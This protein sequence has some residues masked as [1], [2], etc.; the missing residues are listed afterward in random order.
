MY[1]D[2]YYDNE[3]GYIKNCNIVNI[4]EISNNVKYITI[5][6]LKAM[7][8]E[9]PEKFPTFINQITER[10]RVTYHNKLDDISDFKNLDVILIE[11]DNEYTTYK[12]VFQDQDNDLRSVNI[13]NDIIIGMEKY[14]PYHEDIKKELIGIINE[15][16]E[17]LRD[18]N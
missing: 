6:S 12:V 18:G 3:N 4:N 8:F 13:Y 14:H 10:E 7:V 15:M 16:Y 1:S 9:N 17:I 2:Y 5:N 11:R